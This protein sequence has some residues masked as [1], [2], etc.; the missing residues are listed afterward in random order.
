MRLLTVLGV[1]LPEI[2][3]SQF[4]RVAVVTVERVY[5]SLCLWAVDLPLPRFKWSRRQ[6]VSF[7]DLP[8]AK[9]TQ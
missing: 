1:A 2:A 6:N 5:V 3:L 4:V 7:E 8:T 9:G